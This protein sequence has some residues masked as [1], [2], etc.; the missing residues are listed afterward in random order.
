M[1]VR[2]FIGPITN[3]VI[4]QL[5]PV[6]LLLL[7]GNNIRGIKTKKKQLMRGQLI[8]LLMICIDSMLR[9]YKNHNFNHCLFCKLLTGILCSVKIVNIVLSRPISKEKKNSVIIIL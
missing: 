4:E 3:N 2:T 7:C 1:S 5:L 6:L 8:A 9:A